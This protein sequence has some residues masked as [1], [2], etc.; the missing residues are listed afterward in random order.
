MTSYVIRCMRNE[1]FRTV[2]RVESPEAST[3][4]TIESPFRCSIPNLCR[5][6]ARPCAVG[7]NPRAVSVEISTSQST[8]K[9]DPSLGNKSD[10][11]RWPHRN[12]PLYEFSPDV[13][14]DALTL[15]VLA[16]KSYRAFR[17]LSGTWILMP[18][19]ARTSSPS[20]HLI[21]A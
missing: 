3:F 17:P 18:E 16:Q 5:S 20:G 8:S 19:T 15:S 6:Q 7:F 12:T 13:E 1:N 2:R 4:S 14:D 11:G 21:P 9:F 10:E